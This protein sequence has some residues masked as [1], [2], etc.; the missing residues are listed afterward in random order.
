MDDPQAKFALKWLKIGIAVQ[1]TMTL[2]N[3]EGG[4]KAIHRATDRNA[5]SSQG[6][7]IS[8][9][10]DCVR[11]K[12]GLEDRQGLKISLRGAKAAFETNAL[13]NFSERQGC[14]ADLFPASGVEKPLSFGSEPPVEKINPNGSIDNH[15][16]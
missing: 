15:H 2:L 10:L 13:K 9:G 8:S 4:Q 5:K 11:G 1:Q 14:Q 12:H 7:V 16:S 6:A 3:A